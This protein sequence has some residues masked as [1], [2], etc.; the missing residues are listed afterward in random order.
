MSELLRVCRAGMIVKCQD[1]SDGHR[2]YPRHVQLC[3]WMKQQTG[4]DPHDSAVVVRCGGNGAH[5]QGTPHYMQQTLSY[6]LI[7]KWKTK[8]P[9]RPVRF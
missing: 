4:L 6:F 8:K 5:R 2:Y 7:W 3:E 1:G 9:Y